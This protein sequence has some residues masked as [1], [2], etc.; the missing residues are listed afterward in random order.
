MKKRNIII[1]GDSYSTYAGCI[2]EGYAPYYTG[3]GERV[4]DLS[5]AD[6]TWWGLMLKETG[7][8]LVRN[9]SWSGSPI[10]YRGYNETDVS[11]SCS[12][13]YRL[14]RLREDGYFASHNIDT[15]LVFGGTN[16]SWC[17]AE[18]GEEMR[19]GWSE[20]DLYR[21]LPAIWHYFTDLRATFPGAEIYA[22]C[23]C[24]INEMIIDTMQRAAMSV[25]A[26]PIL[27]HDIDKE[28]EHPTARG[29]VEIK[30][31]VMAVLSK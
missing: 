29:M 22:I 2:P 31:Q 8:N 18:I 13:I 4:P 23:N 5:S 10:C 14:R 11:K 17:G 12:F 26:T 21:V 24:G 6:Q 15:V 1:F 19:D 27:L 25:G 30:D 28:A 7:Y 3:T 9:D 20:E 16:D